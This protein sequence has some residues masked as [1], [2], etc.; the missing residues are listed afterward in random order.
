MA[1]E[2]DEIQLKLSSVVDSTKGIDKAIGNLES[3]KTAVD[4]LSK[5]DISEVTKQVKEFTEAVN[6]ARDIS[7]VPKYI[8]RIA[9]KTASGAN[10]TWL[11]EQLGDQ[12][13]EQV[14]S[15]QIAEWDGQTASATQSAEQ[16]KHAMDDAVESTRNAYE[17]LYGLLELYPK[18]KDT[19]LKNEL[20]F[21]TDTIARVRQDMYMM[22]EEEK[23]ASEIEKQKARD[24]REYETA[25]RRAMKAQEEARKEAERAEKAYAKMV[26]EAPQSADAVA[27][28][29]KETKKATKEFNV[30][31]KLASRLKNL[32]VYRALRAII[33]GIA[34]AIKEGFKN[35][36]DWDRNI[37]STGFADAM[38]RARESL[39]VLKNSLAVITAPALEWLIGILQKVATWAMTGANAIS[40]FFAILGGKSTYRAVV[41]ADTL[42]DSE[43]KAG[44]SAKK[45]TQE[46]KKQLLAFDEI[47]NITAQNDSGSG[48][49][50]GSGSGAKYSEMFEEREVGEVSET[51]SK[52]R[53]IWEWIKK[54]AEQLKEA[55]SPLKQIK[56]T[57]ARVVEH[58]GQFLKK[59]SVLKTPLDIIWQG[60]L[61]VVNAV[62]RLVSNVI[63][64]I[65]EVIIIF[66]DILGVAID[67]GDEF[68]IWE[69][70]AK[71]IKWKLDLVADAINIIAVGV[72]QATAVVEFLGTTMG[73]L[74][75]V[76]RGK[77]S[78]AEFKQNTADAF[79]TMQ[80][81]IEEA[82]NSFESKIGVTFDKKRAIN[83]DTKDSVKK[84]SD[85]CDSISRSI[86]GV[87]GKPHLVNFY[88]TENV[89][90]YV[91]E[92][93]T[94]R[95]GK[96]AEGGFPTQGQLFI[97]REAGAEMVG[98]IGGRTA[99]ANNDQIVSAVSQGVAQAVAS[100]MGGGSN[101]TV[102]LEGDAK[103]IFKVV[104]K[105]GRAYS[106]RTGQP[107]LA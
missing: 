69:D 92:L 99:V 79:Q 24:M 62:A 85:A 106:A 81:K 39:L 34:D 45:A 7:E 65:G 73:N 51:E 36:E 59:L 38:D 64:Y 4:K 26:A 75:E 78:L 8:R 12:Y 15:G 63:D 22:A 23:R 37:G 60:V 107:A 18:T 1:I 72:K 16:L 91:R 87:S 97:A 35:L 83:F 43:A 54:C 46:F 77:Q 42:A 50:G 56:D 40:R 102:T 80:T 95:S 49:G 31:N 74:W 68:G 52:L 90:R 96:F 48:G 25:V 9:E 82:K 58:T 11:Q 100:V 98:S 21:D 44:S 5:T 53:A 29:V 88:V 13:D 89:T 17:E 103:G 70:T 66:E 27:K 61:N 105:E 2:Y 104:Q 93:F 30:L 86:A 57:F 55:L 71:D 6:Q 10:K 33:S 41:W 19:Y 32:L 28:I 14:N 47:N 84:V 67:I 94:G 20:G 101:V 76:I 3:A